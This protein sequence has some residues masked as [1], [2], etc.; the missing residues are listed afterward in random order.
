MNSERR[1]STIISTFG[2]YCSDQFGSQTE[3]NEVPQKMNISSCSLLSS[4]LFKKNQLPFCSN[5]RMYNSINM[6]PF[7]PA[8]YMKAADIWLHREGIFHLLANYLLIFWS[9]HGYFYLLDVPPKLWKH[10]KIDWDGKDHSFCY[11]LAA[12]AADTFVTGNERIKKEG[13]IVQGLK[14]GN[15]KV[16]WSFY[17]LQMSVLIYNA[18]LLP[19]Q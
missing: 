4:N 16:K 14:R 7:W 6:A 13:K 18:A 3:L 19:G 15:I 2:W 12:H 1:K 5:N 8:I 9:A 11:C 17:V 10:S